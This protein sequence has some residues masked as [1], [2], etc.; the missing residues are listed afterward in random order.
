M[1]FGKYENVELVAVPRPYLQWLKRQE[2]LGEWLVVEI[3][4]VLTGKVV[5]ESDESFEEALKALNEENQ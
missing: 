3:N 2:W 5:A 1:P 4:D